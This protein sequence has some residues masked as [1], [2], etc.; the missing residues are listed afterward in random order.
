MQQAPNAKLDQE[1]YLQLEF[2]KDNGAFVER[3]LTKPDRKSS[4]LT[5]SWEH[6]TDDFLVQVCEDLIKDF[7]SLAHHY[8]DPKLQK[9]RDLTERAALSMDDIK[10]RLQATDDKRERIKLHKEFM[11]NFLVYVDTLKGEGLYTTARD[12]GVLLHM[13]KHVMAIDKVDEDQQVELDVIARNNLAAHEADQELL[14]NL[15]DPVWLKKHKFEQGS[16]EVK[17]AISVLKLRI[18]NARRLV[19]IDGSTDHMHRHDLLESNFGL[20]FFRHDEQVKY[21]K[22]AETMLAKPM[23]AVD[24]LYE[25]LR[26]SKDLTATA[27]GH[28]LSAKI[29]STMPRKVNGQPLNQKQKDKLKKHT[30]RLSDFV[31]E[32][33]ANQTLSEKDKKKLIIQAVDATVVRLE[34]NG[35]YDQAEWLSVFSHRH[36]SLLGLGREDASEV[37]SD[38]LRKETR[39]YFRNTTGLGRKFRE[40]FLPRH[41]DA[42]AH[43]FDAAKMMSKMKK[44]ASKEVDV[45]SV[46]SFN[47]EVFK[48]EWANALDIIK[49]AQ[50]GFM[51]SYSQI[52]CTQP[53]FH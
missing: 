13:Q 52:L 16:D 3:P 19:G 24:H 23:T 8:D 34:A 36:H 7:E 2:L 37:M 5:K 41:S 17:E 15:H 6:V 28:E 4:E 45:A 11:M 47:S 53:D 35:L 32:V 18:D 21:Q 9:L 39:S 14:K 44:V 20:A 51:G 30:D 22:K 29:L 38:H 12:H 46:A 10:Q 50:Y 48:H 43:E 27:L 31:R 42:P 26:D 1:S 33:N 49:E 25:K 40:Q